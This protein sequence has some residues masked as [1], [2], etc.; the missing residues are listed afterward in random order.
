[1][2]IVALVGS[3]GVGKTTV[4]ECMVEQLHGWDYIS[5]AAEREAGHGY[6]SLIRKIEN[7]MVPTIV[8]IDMLAPIVRKALLKHDVTVILVH[9]MERERVHRLRQRG[10]TPGR[11]LPLQQHNAKFDTTY[12]DSAGID[13]LC[14]MAGKAHAMAY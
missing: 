1:M 2:R 12:L 8:E 14:V 11:A 7:A 9:C 10:D 3:P 13:R 4:A 6:A 5:L